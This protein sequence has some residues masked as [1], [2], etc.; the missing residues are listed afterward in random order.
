MSRSL[1]KTLPLAFVALA[2]IAAHVYL[3]KDAEHAPG[4]LA[5]L[6]HVF[7]LTV[8]IMLAAVSVCVGNM[9]CERFR[10]R[11][12][13]LGEEI[14]FSLFVGAGLIGISVLLFGLAGWLRPLPIALLMLVFI[15]ATRGSWVR[16]NSHGTESI[17]R[18]S[19]SQETKIVATV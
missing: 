12:V 3:G 1:Y 2:A 17:Q 8:A 19:Q 18:I 16:L 7:D 10:V 4:L 15:V 5:V 9:I 13:S 14:G 11:F 6:D